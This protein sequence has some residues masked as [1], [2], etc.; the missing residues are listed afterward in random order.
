MFGAI[1]LIGGLLSTSL[2]IYGTQ[3]QGKAS[4]AAANYN[5][6]LA[7]REATNFEAETAENI[8]RNRINNRRGLAS[9]RVRLASSGTLATSGSTAA[10]L[11]DAAGTLEIGIADAARAANLRAASIRQQGQMQLFNAKQQQK[12]ASL[13]SFGLGLSGLTSAASTAYSNYQVGS[14]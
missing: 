10:V 3:Q 1:G 2:Q 14:R 8:R 13:Q 4:L 7:E 9:L 6:A 5:N 12:A 11:A